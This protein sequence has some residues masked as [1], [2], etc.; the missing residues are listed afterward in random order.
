MKETELLR[1][2]LRP[3]DEFPL[4][5]LIVL[6][7]LAMAASF[8]L[9]TFKEASLT[10]YLVGFGII[11]LLLSFLTYRQSLIVT[12][13]YFR[14]EY[15]FLDLKVHRQFSIRD[16]KNLGVL[17]NVPYEFKSGRTK[18]KVL[19]ID[20]SEDFNRDTHPQVLKFDYRGNKIAF[21]HFKKAFDAEKIVLIVN[22]RIESSK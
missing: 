22:A 7:V 8:Y 14:V 18:V 1:V 3:K 17:N 10:A 16:I 5:W 9:N 20:F 12:E 2:R 19:G 6:I 13:Y 15:S 21:G 11:A 4:I